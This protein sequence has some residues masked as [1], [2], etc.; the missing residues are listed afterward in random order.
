GI[1]MELIVRDRRYRR[2]ELIGKFE[3][4]GFETLS[5]DLVRLGRSDAPLDGRDGRAK[6][7]L[8]VG[9]RRA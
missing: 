6:E 4:A 2:D 7:I 3:A 9:C 1:P 8:Y 5:C